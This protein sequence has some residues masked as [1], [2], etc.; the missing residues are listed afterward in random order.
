MVRAISWKAVML[1]HF[2]F[3]LFLE[4]KYLPGGLLPTSERHHGGKCTGVTQLGILHLDLWAAG[5]EREGASYRFSKSQSLLTVTNS[6]QQGH[7]S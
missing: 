2:S 5:R 7:T 3:F 4:K 1:G 6:L